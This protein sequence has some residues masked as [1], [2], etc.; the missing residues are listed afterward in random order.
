MATKVLFSRIA[1]AADFTAANP[2]LALGET[3]YE[4]DTC[5][6]KV[7]DG[8]TDW[9]TLP[10]KFEASEDIA[11]LQAMVT[12]N[13]TANVANAAASALNM[14]NISAIQ[15]EQTQQNSDIGDNTTD[16]QTHVGNTNNPHTTT[17]SQVVTAD[18]ATDIT[19][20]EAEELTNASVTELHRHS[21]IYIPSGAST[22]LETNAS[23]GIILPAY[24]ST[25]NDGV[26]QQALTTINAQG[27]AERRTI[28]PFYAFTKKVQT[29]SN[30]TTTEAAYDTLTVTLPEA[31]TYLAR[32][33]C[34]WSQNSGATDINLVMN[35]DGNDIF[36]LQTEP[37][38]VAGTGA[39]SI[40]V[41]TGAAIATTGTD[42]RYHAVL[43]EIDTFTAGA[44][45]IELQWG[46]TTTND[47]A[48]IYRSI[49]SI[50]RK[51]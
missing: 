3:G 6:L 42:Q 16:I 25:R 27:L 2:I 10:Y 51:A 13:T 33:W 44:H 26:S 14:T 24:P 48:T 20:A 35:I 11:A 39:P 34:V 46:A 40:D 12:A 29:E 1:T 5:R 17:F 7:G 38:D 31:G 43:E 36:E 15:T 37:Q 21:N 4:Q 41:N 22:A 30:Q 45:T 32:I 9:N 8:S 23:S 18:P 47:L 19:T 50:E 28:L 49:I